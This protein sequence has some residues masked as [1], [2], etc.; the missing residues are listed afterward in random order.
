[1][2]IHWLAPIH[3][4]NI[5]S[6]YATPFAS[7]RL[8]AGA[9][10][11]VL[12]K[13]D[14]LTAGPNIPSQAD[15][16]VVGK[17]GVDDLEN[18]QSLW[19]NQMRRFEG[20]VVLDFTDD[21][22][23]V[24]S[25]MTYFYIQ[26]LQRT[27]IAVCSSQWLEKKLNNLHKGPTNVITDAI[28]CPIIPPKLKPSDHLHILWFGHST[29]LPALIDFLPS[30]P[31]ELTLHVLTNANGIQ[32]IKGLNNNQIQLNLEPEM[33]SPQAMVRTAIK[34]Q[35]C[36]IPV[37]LNNARKAGVS[38]NRLLTALALGLPTSADL[39]DSYAEF[40]NDFADIRS[41]EFTGMLTS[42]ESWHARIQEVQTS[43]L[44]KYS[45]SELGHQWLKL[46]QSLS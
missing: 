37:G 34:C 20:K 15:V 22:V 41:A 45:F 2:H 42:P 4:E 33:W 5:H 30:I 10:L 36:V 39:T 19:I 43:T 3:F 13:T 6:L 29:N 11:S 44:P 16:C 12:P 28:E 27:D 14:F 7:L 18:R 24:G 25:K 31:S 38:S 1:M 23:T 17:I 32:Q 26:A 35:M 8:R 21:R 40:R 46:L 9:L